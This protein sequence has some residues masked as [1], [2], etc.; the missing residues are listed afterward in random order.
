MPYIPLLMNILHAAS[1]HPKSNRALSRIKGQNCKLQGV[2]SLS[3]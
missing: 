3:L 2:S 1:L